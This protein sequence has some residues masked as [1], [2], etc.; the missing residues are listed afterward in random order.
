MSI[1]SIKGSV[2]IKD[3]DD[4]VIARYNNLIVDAGLD[5]IAS[6]FAFSTGTRPTH[7]AMGAGTE[8]TTS[9]MTALQGTEH[10]RVAFASTTS[11]H[12]IVSYEASMGSGVVGSVTVS[13]FGIFTA[14][15]GGTMVN[16]MLANPFTIDSN[17]TITVGWELTFQGDS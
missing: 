7:I 5:V 12:G 10:E 13:E 9:T 3:E 16:R 15:S 4:E 11:A 6:A 14:S 8:L 1:V 2:V 17:N